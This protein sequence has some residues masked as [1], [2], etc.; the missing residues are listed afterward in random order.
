MKSYVPQV[1]IGIAHGQIVAAVQVNCGGPRLTDALDIAWS[2]APLPG[3]G[4]PFPGGVGERPVEVPEPRHLA[5]IPVPPPP[6]ELEKI[7]LAA[8]G[9][10]FHV[11]AG[12]DRDDGA[13]RPAITP[14]IF[15]LGVPCSSR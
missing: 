15:R 14:G 6:G 9:D 2:A 7:L 12:M 1:Q 4:V 11:I 3:E 5:E 10:I 13:W 8:Q